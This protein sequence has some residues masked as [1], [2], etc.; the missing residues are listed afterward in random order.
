[1]RNV[2]ARILN[3][4][5]IRTNPMSQKNKAHDSSEGL[6]LSLKVEGKNPLKV[7]LKAGFVL[8][9][10]ISILFNIIPFLKKIIINKFLG[11]AE[12]V[13]AKAESIKLE[14]FKPGCVIKNIQFNEVSAPGDHAL[15]SF[16]ELIKVSF[17]RKFLWKGILMC[18][19]D[20]H[21][22][23]F[24]FEKNK[25]TQENKKEK[26]TNKKK[27]KIPVAVV[28]KQLNVTE[29]KIQYIDSTLPKI[30]VDVVLSNIRVR[31]TNLSTLRS[32]DEL[33]TK[34]FLRANVYN[35][36]LNAHLKANVLGPQPAFDLDA[37]LTGVN[38]VKLNDFFKAYGNF[39]VNDGT[40]SFFT[41]VA[42]KNGSY[43]GYVK[44]V[45]QNLDVFGPEDR[46]DSLL[47]KLWEMFVGAAAA[48][49]T[50][51]REHQLA[52]KIPFEGSYKPDVHIGYT[53]VETLTNAFINALKPSID[54]EINIGSVKGRG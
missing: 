18:N 37:E 12:D 8:W 42:A 17:D 41:E 35:G 6:N 32:H 50:N 34:A 47:H 43:K 49:I 4:G 39:D 11:K 27:F 9:P 48:I 30:N 28:I 5:V 19:A 45:I 29:S 16:A 21:R 44:P 24:S 51:P 40:L 15:Q 22:L 52:T 14:V 1:M 13:Y 33:P 31:I 38:M 2:C 10:V 23:V 54:N 36:V 46:Q 20:V 25:K 7:W 53:I 26:P 3:N